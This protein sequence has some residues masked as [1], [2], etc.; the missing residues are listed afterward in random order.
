ML[1][2]FVTESFYDCVIP[3]FLED[4]PSSNCTC[5][6][7]SID[8]KFGSQRYGH[9]GWDTE[10]HL[11][12]SRFGFNYL[13]NS[14][15]TGTCLRPCRINE[16]FGKVTYFY[17]EKKLPHH[18]TAFAYSFK[19]PEAKSVE[20]EFIIYELIGVIAATGGALGLCK[21]INGKN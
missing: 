10:E 15:A 13:L 1:N 11:C 12:A 4:F 21:N 3:K 8:K 18:Q 20:E 17:E 2:F 19:P 5:F 6:A 14:S 9:C 7:M 16:Y